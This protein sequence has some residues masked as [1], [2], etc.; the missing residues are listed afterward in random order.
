VLDRFLVAGISRTEFE[1]HLAAGRVRVDGRR[2]IDP[3]HTVPICVERPRQD[4]AQLGTG[5]LV[6]GGV[7]E[8]Q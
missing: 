1:A 3:G 4:T 5:Q 7:A 8:L 6:V 2:V